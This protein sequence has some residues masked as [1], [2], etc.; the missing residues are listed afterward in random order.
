MTAAPV[1]VTS[2]PIAYSLD[3]S[4]PHRDIAQLAGPAK[5]GAYVLGLTKARFNTRITYRAT[6]LMD[7]Q[8]QQECLLPSITVSL[9]Y[10]SVVVYIGREFPE[11]SC[12]YR[13]VLVHELQHVQAFQTHLAELESN[14]RQAMNE[15]FSKPV[16][17]AA[18]QTLGMLA[19]EVSATW[20][21]FILAEQRKVAELQK[22]I[23]T[24]EE[25]RRVVRSCGG[26]VRKAI[27]ET[28]AEPQ[29]RND[30]GE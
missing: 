26:E 20:K 13:E 16:Y 15:R 3:T 22:V 27:L 28:R 11:G 9:S 2:A 12:G 24:P 17:G 4:V 10:P 23:D 6:V 29:P 30:P 25:S 5:T 14:V 19:Q 21:P 8:T 7:K 18:G 1:T